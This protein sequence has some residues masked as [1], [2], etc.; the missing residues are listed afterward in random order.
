MNEQMTSNV[1]VI[2][3]RK[4]D[5]FGLSAKETLLKIIYKK[6]TAFLNSSNDP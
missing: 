2:A 1:I 5:N 3:R 6:N 4:D